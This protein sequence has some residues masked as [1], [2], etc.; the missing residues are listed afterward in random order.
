MARLGLQGEAAWNAA[1]E[2]RF[3]PKPSRM[4]WA[5]YERIVAEAEAC[6]ER[7]VL[8]LMPGLER[9]LGRV[10]AAAAR[11]GARRR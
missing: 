2:P 10:E 4:R 1:L 6:E 5:T 9:F 7:R 8:A 11:R 3:A